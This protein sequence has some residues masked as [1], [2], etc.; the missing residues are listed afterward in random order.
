MRWSDIWYVSYVTPSF[1]VHITSTPVA[2]IPGKPAG[3]SLE[4]FVQGKQS[5]AVV[6]YL[7]SKGIPRKWIEIADLT[8]K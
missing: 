6:D 7:Q 8:G 3:S 1:L 2:P 5:K 4:V